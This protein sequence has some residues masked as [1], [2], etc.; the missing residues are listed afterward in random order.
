MRFEFIVHRANHSTISKLVEVNGEKISAPI[1]S[2]EVELTSTNPDCGT[3]IH[4]FVG[5]EINE[6]IVKFKPGTIIGLEG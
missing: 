1:P 4:R 3:Y 5:A 6:A 2:F